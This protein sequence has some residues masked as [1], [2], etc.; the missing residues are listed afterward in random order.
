MRSVM[1]EVGCSIVYVRLVASAL[2]EEA[3]PGSA[4]WR[5]RVCCECAVL[6]Q[7]HSTAPIAGAALRKEKGGGSAPFDDKRI[8]KD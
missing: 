7:G 3:E 4:T 1:P 5:R 6:H 8:W 2:H